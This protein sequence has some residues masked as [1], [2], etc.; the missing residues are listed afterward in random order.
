MTTRRHTCRCTVCGEE[1]KS[2]HH[3]NRI[4]SDECR[5]EQSRVSKELYRYR[6]ANGLIG[7]RRPLEPRTVAPRA[8]TPRRAAT[9]ADTPDTPAIAAER[10]DYLTGAAAAT[11]QATSGSRIGVV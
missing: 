7:D 5:R 8:V 2:V 6:V 11:M 10:G 3:R 1:F 9:L 4:C